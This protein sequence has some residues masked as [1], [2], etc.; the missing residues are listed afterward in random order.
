[1]NESRALR[2]HFPDPCHHH[3]L[4]ALIRFP[5]VKYWIIRPYTIIGPSPATDIGIV[6]GVTQIDDEFPPTTATRR[7][8]LGKQ[9]RVI[10][11]ASQ[12]SQ[13]TSKH[14][15]RASRL[16]LRYLLQRVHAD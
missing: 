8:H 15:R 3:R 9:E 10:I 16:V 4:R 13:I 12:H 1:M 14:M 2:N 5:P 7:L 11:G 6:V